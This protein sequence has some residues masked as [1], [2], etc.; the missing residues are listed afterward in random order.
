[1]CQQ[2]TMVSATGP[3]RLVPAIL[4][5]TDPAAELVFPLSAAA[6]P[7]LRSRAPSAP[8]CGSTQGDATG[9]VILAA[10]RPWRLRCSPG[11]A[12]SPAAGEEPREV[13]VR[14]L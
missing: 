8:L 12:P 7:A 6:G 14:A 2:E 1:M 9:R 10:L 5:G 4:A 3:A 11:A 13:S